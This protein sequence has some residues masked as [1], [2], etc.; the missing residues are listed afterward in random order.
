MSL[1]KS[2]QLRKEIEG[3]GIET[4]GQTFQIMELVILLLY[5]VIKDVQ[6]RYDLFNFFK[7]II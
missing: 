4:P 5:I 1:I 6:G 7:K 2:L 3:S